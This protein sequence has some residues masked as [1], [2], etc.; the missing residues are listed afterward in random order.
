[1]SNSKYKQFLHLIA[2]L[3]LVY[4]GFI[5][6]EKRH[7]FN[8]YTMLA[9]GCIFLFAAGAYKWLSKKIKRVNSVIILLESAVLAYS[10]WIYYINEGNDN[11]TMALI[12]SL[13]VILYFFSGVY[14]LFKKN[15][16]RKIKRSTHR[17]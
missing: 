4:H 17:E 14:F 6:L 8:S 5:S 2:G 11:K 12:M 16:S 13:L 9:A 15:S 10:G 1:M 7:F 3:L